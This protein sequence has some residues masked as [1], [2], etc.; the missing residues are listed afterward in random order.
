MVVMF[1]VKHHNAVLIGG[2]VRRDGK[3]AAAMDKGREAPY[4]F[5]FRQILQQSQ[6]ACMA[7]QS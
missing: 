6:P 5:I 1:H 3:M 2:M 4:L 7:P